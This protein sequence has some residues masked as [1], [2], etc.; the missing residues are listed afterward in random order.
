LPITHFLFKIRRDLP[1]EW[2][3]YLPESYL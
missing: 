3:M 1:E 2:T